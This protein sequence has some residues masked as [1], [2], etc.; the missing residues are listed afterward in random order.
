MAYTPMTLSGFSG[1]DPSILQGLE[2]YKTNLTQ[3]PIAEQGREF[4]VTSGLGQQQ[5]NAYLQQMAEQGREFDVTSGMGQQQL[6]A[7]LKQMAD[8]LQQSKFRQQILQS[9]LN[10]PATHNAALS[11][12]FGG[13]FGSNPQS[14]LANSLA[15]QNY[16][17]KQ[18]LEPSW[19]ERQR[20]SLMSQAEISGASGFGPTGGILS[21]QLAQY[22]VT[23]GTARTIYPTRSSNSFINLATQPV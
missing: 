13:N 22:G 8:Q 11:A 12:M 1:I 20:N 15:T 21:D 9:A 16:Y 6:S 17:A 7:Y 3:L 14:D 4:D 2:A 5:L 19:W 18:A 23:P 10:N